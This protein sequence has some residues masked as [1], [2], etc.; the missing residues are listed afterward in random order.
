M[1]ARSPVPVFGFGNTPVAKRFDKPRPLAAFEGARQG[2]IAGETKLDVL[3]VANA[4]LDRAM[5]S[6]FTIKV[7]RNDDS[8]TVLVQVPLD[9]NAWIAPMF[10]ENVRI[11]S[12]FE[13][14]NTR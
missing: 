12:E 8:T 6:D 13:L 1:T 9:K 3:D 10:F 5:L 2:T 4:I 14:T 7:D 11:R